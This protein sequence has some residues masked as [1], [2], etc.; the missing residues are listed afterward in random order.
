MELKKSKEANIERLRLPII[1]MSSLFVGSIVLAS[2]TFRSEFERNNTLDKAQSDG[3]TVYEE[4]VEDQPEP[5]TPPPP[6]VEAPPPITEDVVEEENT[7]EIPPPAITPPAPPVTPGP[8]TPPKVELEIV[9]FPDVEAGFPGGAAEM[10]RFISE[11]V[12]YPQTA[13]EMNEQGRVYLSFVVE[14]DGKITNIE[15]KRGVS[16]DLD[17]EAKRVLRKMPKWTPGEAGGKKVRTRC[18]LPINFTLQ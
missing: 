14:P 17:R 10:Q 15:V 12:E 13:I 4:Q 16:G 18:S 1:L 11:N 6:A 8:T 9:D 7:E 5:E 3:D 2:F